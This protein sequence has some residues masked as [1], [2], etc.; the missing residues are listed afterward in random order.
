MVAINRLF[1]T[2]SRA[3]EKNL[4]EK[5][6]TSLSHDMSQKVV[7]VCLLSSMPDEECDECCAQYYYHPIF[8]VLVNII[9]RFHE[10]EL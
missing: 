10:P 3:G 7:V 2:L 8:N 9:H 1:R 4:I 5:L 6:E